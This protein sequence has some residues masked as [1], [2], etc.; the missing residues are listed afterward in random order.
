MLSNNQKFGAN[1]IMII[2]LAALCDVNIG[3][4][5]HDLAPN[6][7]HFRNLREGQMVVGCEHSVS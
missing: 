6:L 5:D 3:S 4:N 2:Q 1:T 7:Y